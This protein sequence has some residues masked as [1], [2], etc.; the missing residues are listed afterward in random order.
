MG[1]CDA[2]I[3]LSCVLSGSLY[4]CLCNSTQFFD[5]GAPAPLCSK[6]LIKNIFNLFCFK[7][8]NLNS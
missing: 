5:T 3:G 8:S 7:N 6:I 2:S 4:K 1:E